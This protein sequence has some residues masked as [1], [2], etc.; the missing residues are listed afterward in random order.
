[1]IYKTKMAESVNC[2]RKSV[3]LFFEKIFYQTAFLKL[4]KRKF[5]VVLKG[6]M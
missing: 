4:Q 3:Q 1:M 2:R 6:V 5:C